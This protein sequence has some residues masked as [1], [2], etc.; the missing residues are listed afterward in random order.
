M[1]IKR[2]DENTLSCTLSQEDLLEKGFKLDD[3]FEKKK[4]AVDYIRSVVAEAARAENF[5]MEGQIM[6]M[7]V[8]VLPDRSLNLLITRENPG[9][10]IVQH[11]R[12]IAQSIMESIAAQAME[13]SAGQAEKDPVD[14]LVGALLGMDPGEDGGGPSAKDEGAR[15]DG[16]QESRTPEAS[17]DQPKPA[18][19]AASKKKGRR[20]GADSFMFS[21]Y[22][23]RDAMDCCR[24]FEG[25]GEIDSA[26]YYLREDDT[27]FLILHRNGFTPDSYERRIISANDFGELVTTNEK[28]ISFVTEHGVPIMR[29]RA[30][31]QLLSGLPA[32]KRRR[33]RAGKPEEAEIS[34]SPAEDTAAEA[35]E[36]GDDGA[37]TSAGPGA[38]GIQAAVDPED[39]RAGDAADSAADTAEE[40]SEPGADG[41]VTSADQSGPAEPSEE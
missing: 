34:L 17:Q 30:I 27:Y 25:A 29:E 8:S 26:L 15:D 23:L 36:P 28:Y 5:D 1:I 40:A 18:D 7:R 33:K 22:T 6:M 37:V 11:V 10:G 41:A 2:I 19:G 13:E 38:D 3:F 31:E 21:F 9:E 12:R 39:D 35:S 16:P 32:K 24:V 4:E 20:S 14:D